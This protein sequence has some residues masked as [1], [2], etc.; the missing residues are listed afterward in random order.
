MF[1]S[2]LKCVEFVQL[3]ESL[4]VGTAVQVPGHS[5]TAVGGVEG[6]TEGCKQFISGPAIVP[7]KETGQASETLIDVL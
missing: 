2:G 7:V 1:E 4:P 6:L 3:T 5:R